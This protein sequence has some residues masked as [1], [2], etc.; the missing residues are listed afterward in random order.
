[1]LEIGECPG[2]NGGGLDSLQ[3]LSGLDRLTSV[4]AFAMVGNDALVSLQGAPMFTQMNEVILA[5]NPLLPESAI[6]EFLA[7][8]VNPNVNVCTDDMCQCP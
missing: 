8:N 6:S 3:D 1:M 7:Q 5:K 4:E 2:G